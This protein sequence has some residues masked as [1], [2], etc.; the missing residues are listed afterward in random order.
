MTRF[1]GVRLLVAAIVAAIVA[2]SLHIFLQQ[3]TQPIIAHLMIGVEVARPPYGPLIT[4]AAYVTAVVP[5]LVAAVLF[6][7]GAHL[8]PSRSRIAKGLLLGGLIILIK[9]DLIRQPIMNFLIGN[10]LPVVA[11]TDLHAVAA[12]LGLGLAIGLLCP[13]KR[14]A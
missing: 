13:I 8:L 7:Y 10:P 1:T 11:L 14:A 12:N 9:G 3:W 4:T 2:L 6:Y 5:A